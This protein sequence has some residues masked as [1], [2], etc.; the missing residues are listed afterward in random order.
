MDNAY[1]IRV[2]IILVIVAAGG[3]CGGYKWREVK[4]NMDHEARR[5]E[6]TK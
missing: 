2:L 6:W 5:K 4:W 1:V 3:F